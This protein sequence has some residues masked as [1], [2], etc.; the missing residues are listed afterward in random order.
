MTSK[1]IVREI[2]CTIIVLFK[3]LKTILINICTNRKIRNFWVKQWIL[4]RNRL[5][6]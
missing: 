5:R 6:T 1:V 2:V 3:E 4:R